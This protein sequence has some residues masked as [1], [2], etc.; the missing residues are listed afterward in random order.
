[1]RKPQR[2]IK[3]ALAAIKS[4]G[5]KLGIYA[6]EPKADNRLAPRRPMPQS[7]WPDPE[8]GP[9]LRNRAAASV[10]AARAGSR[11]ALFARGRH[12]RVRS[13]GRWGSRPA[14]ASGYAVSF[15]PL[16]LARNLQFN[17]RP[18]DR[19]KLLQF[20]LIFASSSSS[21][22]FG[23]LFSERRRP[24]Q[25]GNPSAAFTTFVRGARRRR[26]A[27]VWGGPWRPGARAAS[28]RPTRGRLCAVVLPVR[29][30]GQFAEVTATR[31]HLVAYPPKGAPP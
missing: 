16:R 28:A 14:C 1:M 22:A 18:E 6:Q 23:A 30:V 27:G 7:R 15:L 8:K 26:P 11:L 19:L 24:P 10:S 3:A 13:S 5:L 9:P 12:A 31:P 4:R 2:Q 21:E 25:R 20:P 17:N 29:Q